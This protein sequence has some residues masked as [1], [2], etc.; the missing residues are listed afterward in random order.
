MPTV[1]E[2]TADLAAE[3]ADLERILEPLA[4][5]QWALATPS[6]GWDIADQVGHLAY[7]DRTA[8][9]AITDP[10]AFKAS[11]KAMLDAI[12]EGGTD[13]TLDEPRSMDAATLMA[14]WQE[15]R[16]GLIEAAG[17]LGERD[18]LPWYGPD[19][20]GKSFLTA[21]LMETW[22]HGQDV[23]DTVGAVRAP[24]DRLRH[25][26]QL[27]FITRGWTYANRGLEMPDTTIRVEL[28][29]P[30]GDTWTWGEDDADETVVGTAEAFCQVVTQ[31]RHA[32][33]TDLVITGAASRDWMTKAQAF[34]G[35]ATD[36]PTA[37]SF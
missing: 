16:R 12:L 4:A 28:T 20:S 10:D 8:A 9:Q 1:A 24:T 6:P 11:A 30:S 21:R 18:R 3:H 34:A 25:I 35:G 5:E 15:G 32:D 17:T 7:F 19:M 27:G 29:A 31:R 33:D 2:I 13:P 36:G 14:W 37:G 22:A 26:A 23:C